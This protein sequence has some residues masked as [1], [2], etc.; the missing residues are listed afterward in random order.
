LIF[1]CP[2]GFGLG[3]ALISIASYAGYCVRHGMA[4]ALDM[5]RLP[6]FAKDAQAGFFDSFI[7]SAPGLRIVSDPAAIDALAAH[8][9]RL[10]LDRYQPLAFDDAPPVP[11][12]DLH[13]GLNRRLAPWYAVRAPEGYSIALKDRLKAEV[14]G[15]LAWHDWI[16]VVGLHYRHGNGEILENREDF[17]TAPDY[18]ARA[19]RVAEGLIEEAGRLA[20]GRPVFVASDN[21]AF[22]A[23]ALERIPSAFTIARDIP[24]R[25]I[26]EFLHDQPSRGLTEAAIDMWALS[27]CAD[28]VCV[29][30]G[31][32]E[33][34]A[35]LN[36]RLKIHIQ[37]GLRLG[38]GRD[39]AFEVHSARAHAFYRPAYP[40]VWRDLANAL[41]TAGD[42][43]GAQAAEDVASRA[44]TASADELEFYVRDVARIGVV[45]ESLKQSLK[46]GKHEAHAARQFAQRLL[47][48][49]Y[50]DL[51]AELVEAVLPA[52]PEDAG[53]W[54]LS[55]LANEKLDRLDP[56]SV[57]AR[58]AVTLQPEVP[59]TRLMLARILKRAGDPQAGAELA[60][61]ARALKRPGAAGGP[62]C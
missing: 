9:D 1:R 41:R 21:R 11:V 32:S 42:A 26:M 39:A 56:A 22:V 19:R 50:P 10:E 31:F 62:A 40:K 38:R 44:V 17:T 3:S 54:T 58:R 6:Y 49:G 25:P 43:D 20:G 60:A 52:H 55:A 53:L 7:L 15:A 61:A 14:E 57:A 33:A 27:S 46:D 18:A 12:I 59:Q 4:L 2:G 28:V 48:S 30:S 34:A 51:A 24:D 8:P 5:R 16:G 23:T 36:P 45:I 47:S 29:T 35:L 13:G 37:D